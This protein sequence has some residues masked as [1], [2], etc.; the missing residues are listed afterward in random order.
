MQDLIRN[1]PL[2]MYFFFFLSFFLFFFFTLTNATTNSTLYRTES[3]TQVV[4]QMNKAACVSCSSDCKRRSLVLNTKRNLIYVSFGSC[5]YCLEEYVYLMDNSIHLVFSQWN[6]NLYGNIKWIVVHRTLSHE[7]QIST[8]N[9]V[10]TCS[11][12]NE[13]RCNLPWNLTKGNSSSTFA[14]VLT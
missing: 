3:Y 5:G 4:W 12:I 13:K 11:Y 6:Y 10:L 8:S 2:N 14:K 9:T 7:I 1:I